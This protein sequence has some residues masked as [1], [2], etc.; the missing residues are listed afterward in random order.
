MYSRPNYDDYTLA[1]LFDALHSV[2]K[3][4]Y[5]ENHQGIKDALARRQ[6]S[7]FKCVKCGFGGYQTSDIYVSQSREESIMDVESGKF[8]SVSCIEC[9][10]TEF[11]RRQ[12]SAFGAVLDLFVR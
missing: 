10:Y 8:F 7:E 4:Q 2:D 9:G 3:E 11:Y 1:E 5:P 6:G 12:A